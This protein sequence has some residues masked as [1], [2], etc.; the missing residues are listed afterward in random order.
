LY[1]Y[2][3]AL[4]LLLAH[5]ASELGEVYLAD[6]D[7]SNAFCNI[8]RE[9]VPSLLRFVTPDLG[10]WL[11]QYYKDFKVH[12]VTPHGLTDPYKMMTG[13]GQGDSGGVAAYLCIGIQ[14]TRF[15]HGVLERA[16][17]PRDLSPG[18]PNLG[19]I[20]PALPSGK[21]VVEI[22]YSDDRRPISKTAE[23]LGHLLDIFCHGCWAAGASVNDSKLQAFRV[24]LSKG[25]L[26]YGTGSVDTVVGNLQFRRSGLALAGIPAVMEPGH[27]VLPVNNSI[28]NFFLFFHFFL[29]S[30][31]SPPPLKQANL[32]RHLLK[33]KH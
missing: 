12:V 2:V 33:K 11:H 18:A 29:Y 31:S 20:C 24:K 4:A 22:G 9:D 5:W 21:P 27:C 28:P 32:H 13:G 6:W 30:F 17:W 10:M 16:L 25:V 14:R 1:E 3:G 7:E 19:D 23:G 15:H 26:T 8:P